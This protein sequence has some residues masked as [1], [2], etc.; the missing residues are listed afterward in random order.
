MR[1]SQFI[2][3]SRF[4][5][6]V[7]S[8]S[9]VWEVHSSLFHQSFILRRV[10]S[11]DCQ[12][13]TV[14]CFIPVSFS[15]EFTYPIFRGAQYIDFIRVSFSSE[16]TFPSVS[17]AQ[18]IDFI[19]GFIQ[20]WVHFPKCQR[21]SLLISFR[22]SF[23]SEFTIPSVRGVQFI[24]SSRFHS[25][26]SSPSPASE[27]HTWLI[28]SAMHWA[29]S[30][31]SRVSEVHSWLISSGCHPALTSL[32]RVSEVYGL[33]ILKGFILRWVHFPEC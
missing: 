10:H 26:V 13:C 11:P 2:F 1:G 6:A 21:C 15:G 25:G 24:V 14:Y 7:S 3:S 17:V 19:Q 20:Q 5:S 29:V 8:L 18:F 22:V 12:R 16:F 31:L 27:V 23:S 30:S 33:L 32:S 28:P 4:D 9:R